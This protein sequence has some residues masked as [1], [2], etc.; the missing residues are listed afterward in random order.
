MTLPAAKTCSQI[1]RP[2]IEHEWN[3]DPAG[4]REPGATTMAGGRDVEHFAGIDPATVPGRDSF[5]A[6]FHFEIAT[7]P[8]DRAFALKLNAGST[9]RNFQQPRAFRISGQKIG[10]PSGMAIECSA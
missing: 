10:D 2:T 5:S 9:K 4:N 1:G 7:A 8:G 3:I 6:G